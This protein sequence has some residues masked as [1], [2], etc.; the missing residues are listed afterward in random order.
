MKRS[1]LML[2]LLAACMLVV[3]L[4]SLS[5]TSATAAPEPGIYVETEVDE[6]DGPAPNGDCSLR[7]EH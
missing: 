7:E 5:A 2:T 4:W 6:A 3:A 1:I